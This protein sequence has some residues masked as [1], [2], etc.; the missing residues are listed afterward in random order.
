[1][2]ALRAPAAPSVDSLRQLLEV[3]QLLLIDGERRAASSGQT[4]EV[5][6]PST[7]LVLTTTSA[8]GP[9]D[10]AAAVAAARAGLTVWTQTSPA[11]R[12]QVLLRLAALLEAHTEELAL[13]ETLDVGK[14]ITASRSEIPAAVA[15]LRSLVT[16]AD[17]VTGDTKAVSVPGAFS[18]TLREP[19][20]VCA[21]I[22]PWN[23]PLLMAVMKIGPALACGNSAILKPAEDAPLT[24]IRLGELAL[25]AG[26]P[27]GVLNVLT[28]IGEVVGAALVA[29]DGVDKVAFTGS[30][31]VG[32][33]ILRTAAEDFKHVTLE[34]GGKSPHVIFA[35]AHREQAINAAADGIFHNAGQNC[36]AGS[37]ILVEAAIY[38]EVVERLL[39]LA[40]RLVVGSP[41]D[42][43]TEQGPLISAAH[44]RRVAGYVDGALTDGC[45]LLVGG[46]AIDGPGF[47]F[48]PTLLSPVRNDIAI[49]QEEVFGPVAT[50]APFD[51]EEHALTLA[52]DSRYGLAAG[53]WTR[54]VGRALRLTRRLDVGRVYVN[55]YGV[56][57]PVTP[58]A[59][60][61][62]SGLG[63]EN[64]R[65]VLE[66]YTLLKNVWISDPDDMSGS[67]E[68]PL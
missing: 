28:G 43:A 51:D 16:W 12:M 15:Y 7:G 56:G 21:A 23:Y 52:N 26:V 14:P 46:K 47:F 18:Y 6:D 34:M 57:D 25:E 45:E 11:R 60:R 48:E 30:T 53:I 19:I 24:P 31:G 49:M 22:I 63:H 40:S 3:E 35:D 20:G 37:R 44:R 50:V 67:N 39:G 10:V 4:L 13:L 58:V 8:A 42:V 38:G 68:T 41:L 54:D 64:G 59:G 36:L 1:M 62:A 5:I 17:K 65:E 9:P 66:E 55:G 33:S 32:R 61:K 27:P 29:N 2:T